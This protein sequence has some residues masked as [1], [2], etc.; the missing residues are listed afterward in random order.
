M[1]SGGKVKEEDRR[2]GLKRRIKEQEFHGVS[3]AQLDEY[4]EM[5]GLLV[6]DW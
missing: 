3:G 1:R 2:G 6:S 5:K 4:I